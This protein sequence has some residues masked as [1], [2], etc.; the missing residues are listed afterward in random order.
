MTNVCM[1]YIYE[2]IY[3]LSLDLVTFDLGLPLKVNSMS[4]TSMLPFH[5]FPQTWKNETNYNFR[6]IEK[7]AVFKKEL[8][9]HL[10]DKY[11]ETVTCENARCR[12]CFPT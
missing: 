4:H 3:D 8:R 7:V 2:V 1:K 11:S 12:Q 9:N 6:A 5:K 10:I